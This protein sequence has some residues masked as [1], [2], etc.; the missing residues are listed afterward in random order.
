MPA[1]DLQVFDLRP[2]GSVKAD[3]TDQSVSGHPAYDTMSVHI[4]DDHNIEVVAKKAGTVVFD[5]KTTVAADGMTTTE[6]SPG[7]RS[8]VTSR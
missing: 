8:R 6:S 4:I 3:G 2:A 1:E 5:E 7:T